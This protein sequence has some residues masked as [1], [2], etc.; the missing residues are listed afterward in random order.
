MS[1]WIELE[2]ILCDLSLKPFVGPTPTPQSH[3][4]CS[5]STD[6]LSTVP[7]LKGDIARLVTGHD[8]RTGARPL[9]RSCCLGPNEVPLPSRRVP[10]RS[11]W[12]VT[13]RAMTNV[14]SEHRHRA[15]GPWTSI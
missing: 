13:G 4:G 2:D 14:T 8:E 9:S 6:D 5:I 12:P 10:V 15:D 1:I 11:S 3:H 7:V